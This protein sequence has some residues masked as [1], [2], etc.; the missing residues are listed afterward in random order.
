[1]AVSIISAHAAF[2]LTAASHRLR[3]ATLR[4]LYRAQNVLDPASQA[5]ATPLPSASLPP[6]CSATCN[7]GYG[8]FSTINTLKKLNTVRQS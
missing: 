5:A 2:E 1:M 3:G 6:T 8:V 7:N 4:E